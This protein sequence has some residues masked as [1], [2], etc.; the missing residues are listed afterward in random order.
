MRLPVPTHKGPNTGPL[1]KY[2]MLFLVKMNLYL[3]E[4]CNAFSYLPPKNTGKKF[5]PDYEFNL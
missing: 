4:T 2:V 3:L 5:A 1:Q